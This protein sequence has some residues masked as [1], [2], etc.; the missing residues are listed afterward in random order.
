MKYRLLRFSLLSVLVMLCGGNIY[1]GFRDI[2]A[3][4]TQLQ[5]LATESNVYIKVAE[6][7]TISQTDNAE[8]ANATLK[9]KWH[10]TA[11]GWSNFTASVPV[12]GCVKIT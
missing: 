2:K 10:G 8:E 11:Y 9:G 6:D 7:G 4:L 3:D 5:N 1:A 12:Q